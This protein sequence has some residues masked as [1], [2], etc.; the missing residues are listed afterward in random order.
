MKALITN[1]FDLPQPVVDALSHDDYS[2][3]ESQRSITQLIDAP[4]YRIL[5]KEHEHEITYDA[6]ELIWIAMGKTLHKMFENFG[7]GKWRPEQRLFAK[8]LGWVVSGQVDVQ[9]VDDRPRLV[10]LYDYKMTSVWSVI[11][12]KEAYDNQLNCYAALARENGLT[13]DGLKIVFIL[14]DWKQGELIRGKSKNYP[15]SPILVQDANMWS[16]KEAADYLEERVRLH[17]EAEFSRLTGEDLPLCSDEER[18]VQKTQWAVKKPKNKTAKKVCYS[19]KDAEKY[20]KTNKLE[21]FEI[22]ERPGQPNR[23][24]MGYCPVAQWCEQWAEEKALLGIK[25][26]R[27]DEPTE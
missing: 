18:W 26:D 24:A 21:G 27:S 2:R 4:R 10:V 15:K 14:R 19:Y 13:V 25:D 16:A 8:V 23:C 17:Q 1:K 20:I 22:I 6:S 3:G 7:G 11:F 12:G 9:E 5:K